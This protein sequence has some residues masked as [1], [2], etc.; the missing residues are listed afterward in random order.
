MTTMPT[1]RYTPPT[2]TDGTITRFAWPGGYRVW[3]VTHDSAVLCAECVE[4]ERELTIDCDPDDNS[5]WRVV[6]HMHDGELDDPVYCD[7]CNRQSDDPWSTLDM[8]DHHV[9]VDPYSSLPDDHP[10]RG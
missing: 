6:G 7:H 5:G 8:V 1:A 10:A 3:Y 4:A 2:D 9:D